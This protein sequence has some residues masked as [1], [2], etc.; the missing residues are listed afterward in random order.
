MTIGLGITTKEG[1][2]LASDTQ[3]TVEG[4]F[5]DDE[6]KIRE[7][8][9]EG[10]GAVV[11]SFAGIPS[12]MNLAYKELEQRLCR[13]GAPGWKDVDKDIGKILS[14]LRV[15]YPNEMDGQQFLFALSS[16]H[17]YPTLYRADRDVLSIEHWSCIGVGD[18]S[19]VR[20]LMGRL[21]NWEVPIEWAMLLA[22]YIVHYAK[23]YIDKVGGATQMFLV[24]AR[25]DV[26]RLDADALTNLA[27][28][29]EEVFNRFLFGWADK[30]NSD[31]VI[32]FAAPTFCRQLAE[33]RNKVYPPSG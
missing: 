12:L 2:V 31:S 27:L 28:E 18:S 11:G 15:R 13:V 32:S 14:G 30:K 6:F 20:F 10:E 33:L 25:G 22:A 16:P 4:F 23:K 3:V 19:L 17:H 7:I 9:F 21:G 24:C 26:S 29:L 1:V 5:K 8:S